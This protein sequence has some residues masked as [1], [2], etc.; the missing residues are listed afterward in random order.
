[1]T[2]TAAIA[3]AALAGCGG[4]SSN[5]SSGPSLSAFKT[6]FQAQK[7]SFTTIGTDLQ[8]AI[9]TASSSSSSKIASEFSSLA[10]RTTQAA[11][12]IRTL[13]PPAKY[14]SE[15]GL[16]AAGF[17][18]VAADLTAVSTAAKNNNVNAARTAAAKLVADSATIHNADLKLTHELGLPVTG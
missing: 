4:S 13:K 3:A 11:A 16:L 2:I 15:V 7:A 9:T 6:G 14:Q 18:T 12:A 8:T 1:M 17:D 5:S 10:S